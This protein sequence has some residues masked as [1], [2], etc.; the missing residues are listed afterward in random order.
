M[1]Y[2]TNRVTLGT[3][4]CQDNYGD[5]FHLTGDSISASGLLADGNSKNLIHGGSY[6]GSGF[7]LSYV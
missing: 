3:I 6:N 5:G 7:L 2:S 1:L 4:D